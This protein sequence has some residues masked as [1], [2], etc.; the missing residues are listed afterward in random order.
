MYPIIG[1]LQCF[2][3]LSSFG[4]VDFDLGVKAGEGVHDV[5]VVNAGIKFHLIFQ[6]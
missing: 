4:E 6:D 3:F 2:A 1:R 5:L